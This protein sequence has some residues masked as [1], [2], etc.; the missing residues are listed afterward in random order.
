MGLDRSAPFHFDVGDWVFL[1][2]A[3]HSTK[4]R[5]AESGH[6]PSLLAL[7]IVPPKKFVDG[8]VPD[9]LLPFIESIPFHTISRQSNRL[10]IRHHHAL[11]DALRDRPQLGVC[12]ALVIVVLH[13][14]LAREVGHHGECEALAPLVVEG[15]AGADRED[16]W[17]AVLDFFTHT[18]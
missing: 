14:I 17:L 9:A 7:K 10:K 1:I 18:D 4:S 11:M 3:Y 5:F 15:R 6:R 8:S 12:L 2:S 13:V 16:V